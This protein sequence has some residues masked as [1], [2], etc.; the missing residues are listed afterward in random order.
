MTVADRIGVMDHGRLVQVATAAGDLRAAELALGRGFHRRREP[1]RGNGRRRGSG[2]N[3]DRKRQRPDAC[4][5]RPAPTR[6]PGDTVWL[7]LRPEKVRIAREPP[8]TAAENCVAGKVRD[9]GYL[10]DLSIYKVRARRAASS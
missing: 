4:A 1:D 3:D 7:A 10:G 5:S 9:I 2:R 8:A 6:K